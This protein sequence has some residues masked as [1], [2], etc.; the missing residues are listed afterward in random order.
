MPK[1]LVVDK[2]VFHSLCCCEEKLCI[3]VKDYSV[4]L[5]NAL[6]I[7]CLISKR[8]TSDKDPAQLVQRFDAAIKA[9]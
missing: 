4:V 9:G 1:L 3:F 2:S 5:P 7:E 6:A 8:Q